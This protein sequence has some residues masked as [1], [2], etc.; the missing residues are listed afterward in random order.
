MA[1]RPSVRF[2]PFDDATEDLSDLELHPG[3]HR[4]SPLSPDDLEEDGPRPP[5][6]VRGT[7]PPLEVMPECPKGRAISYSLT[8]YYLPDVFDDA[9]DYLVCARCHA[10]HIQGTAL[11]VQFKQI[12]WP[13]GEVAACGFRF[14]RVKQV[15]WPE[16]LR[17]NNV[18]PLRDFMTRRLQVK[19]C[20]G[21][22]LTEDTEGRLLYGMVGGEV[23]GFVACEACYE[24]HIAGTSFQSYFGTY[25]EGV[26]TKWSCDMS[27]P[28]ISS[29]AA[30]MSKHNNWNGFVGAARRRLRLPACTGEQI[31]SDA[32]PWYI[33]K[34]YGIDKFQVCETCYLDKLALT[35]F[36]REFQRLSDHTDLEM[37]PCRLTDKNLSTAT[38][39]EAALSRRDFEVFAKAEQ[40][41][42]SLVPCTADGIL[43][44]NWWTIPG[45]EKFNICEAC[46]AG[47]V[48][49]RD[50]DRFFQLSD[51][52]TYTAYVCDFCPASPRFSQYM[53]KFGEM[54][55][56]G[57]F[58]YLSDFVM[59][60]AGV[61]ACPRIK[62]SGKARW[63]GYPEAL[64]C[65]EC[66]VDFVY[67]TP[68]G[69]SLP[70]NGE[71]MEQATICQ[72]WSPRMRDLWLEVCRAGDP[73]S[74]DSEAALAQFKTC[75]VQR[76]QVYE[77]TISQ[78]ELIR[79]MQD[80]KRQTAFS[81]GMLS[82][83]YSGMD[84][85]ATI[86][87]NGDGHRHGNSSLGWF[88][89][90]Y[91]AQSKQYWNSFT[92]GLSDANRTEDWVRI[93]QLEN[94]WKQ[95]E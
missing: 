88:N 63:W 85:M 11:E 38:A 33:S 35:P 10:D 46:Y 5:D 42:C 82:I 44:G 31:R 22:V 21:Q 92:Q 3:E 75:C 81:D 43:Y 87:G 94:L 1:G 76:F 55:D 26:I 74:E 52:D 71:Y 60:F 14:P 62:G 90:S 67:Q 66:F 54:L 29:A 51:R 73:G 83:R 95:V 84:S 12:E 53:C 34:Y 27:I 39:L 7:G 91:G 61:P 56:R 93:A 47:F 80:I 45:C 68:L 15:L 18:N 2:D 17:T 58:S 16:A 20:P 49:T 6:P 30:S 48:Q 77:A 19:R 78:I 36:R 9:A 72:I 32:M 41:I 8:W 13:A 59:T 28:Y 50:L 64:F 79:T 65:H 24:D 89:T 37:W 57:V 25:P 86:F 69:E 40:I 4:S 23:D 70:I